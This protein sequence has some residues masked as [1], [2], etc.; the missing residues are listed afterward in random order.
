MNQPRPFKG[1]RSP[2]LEIAGKEK[3]KSLRIV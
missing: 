3:N 2:P 1:L